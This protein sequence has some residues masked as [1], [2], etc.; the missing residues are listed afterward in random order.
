MGQQERLLALSNALMSTQV[1]VNKLLQSGFAGHQDEFE[2][3]LSRIMS[4]ICILDN[5]GEVELAKIQEHT[6]ATIASLMQ[7]INFRFHISSV[8]PESVRK[9]FKVVD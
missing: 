1:T 9:T 7:E 2:I 4:M 5:I 3:Q 6:N 8:S